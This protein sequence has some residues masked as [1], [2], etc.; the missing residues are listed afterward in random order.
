MSNY[1]RHVERCHLVKKKQENTLRSVV[2]Y[3]TQ[4]N[5]GN[6]DKGGNKDGPEDQT[7]VLSDDKT[8]ARED[9]FLSGKD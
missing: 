7:Q 4:S 9:H 1:L 5:P 6:S 3:L 8:H 2:K